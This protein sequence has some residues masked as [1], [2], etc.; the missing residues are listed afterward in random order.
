MKQSLLTLICLAVSLVGVAFDAVAGDVVYGANSKLKKECLPVPFFEDKPAATLG[1][2]AFMMRADTTDFWSLEDVIVEVVTAG[3]VPT[4][5][6][7][8]R[9]IVFTTPVVDSV[10]V[11]RK[12]HKVEMWVLPDYVAIGTDDDFVRMPMGPMAAQRIADALDCTLP[13]PFLVDRIAEVSEGHVDIFPFRPLGSRNCQPIVFQDSDNAIKAL[14]KAHG[15]R[16]GQFISGLKKD[17]VLTYKIMS[18]VMY[19]DGDYYHCELDY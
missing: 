1:G 7:S 11:L 8:F 13:T 14:F 19:E 4:E 9:K 3:N 18:R 17:I 16:F 5:L 12:K 2:R 15:Y 10:E 6:R